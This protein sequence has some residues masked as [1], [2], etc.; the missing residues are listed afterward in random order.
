MTNASRI[1]RDSHQPPGLH[2]SL[3]KRAV[4]K[5]DCSRSK[6]TALPRYG[7]LIQA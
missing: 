7:A 5:T 3:E 2:D 4:K 1:L 6:P